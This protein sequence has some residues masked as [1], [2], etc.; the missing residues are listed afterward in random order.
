MK[1]YLSTLLLFIF[2]LSSCQNKRTKTPN[3]Q[4]GTQKMVDTLRY[5]VK[6]TD[7]LKDYYASELRANYYKEEMEKADP[8]KRATLMYSWLKELINSGDNKTAIASIQDFISNLKLDINE[9]D[10][11]SRYFFELLALAYLR[12]GEL[13]NCVANHTAES[14][15]FPLAEN[16]I[17]TL[18]SGST[19]AIKIYKQI[20]TR[21]PEDLNSRWLLNVAFMTLGEYPDKV[22]S[23]WLIKGLKPEKK[24]SPVAPFKNVAVGM[25]IDVN[26][27]S[28][29]VCLDDFNNDGNLDIVISSWGPDHQLRVFISDGKGAYTEN[30]EQSGIKGITGG[31][32]LVHADYDN[33]GLLDVFVLRGAWKGMDGQIPNSLL[34]NKGNGQFEDVTFDSGLLSFHPTQVATW[35]DFNNDGWLDLFIANETEASAQSSHPCEFYLNKKNGTFENVASKVGLNVKG[36][37]KGASAG[38]I[39]NDGWIDLFLSNL[40]GSNY[41]FLNEGASS[42]EQ[43]KFKDITKLANVAAPW[44]SFPTW[45]WDYDNDGWLDIFVSTYDSRHM[46][47][48][49]EDEALQMLNMEG[50]VRYPKLYKNKGNNLFSDVTEGVGLNRVMYPMGSNFGDLDNDGYQDFYL[51]TGAP[52]LRSVVPN[53]MFYNNGGTSFQDISYEVGMGHIQKGH[54]IGFADLDNDGDQDIYAVMGGAYPGDVFFN[55]LFE[56]PNNQ[57][58]WLT[59]ALEGTTTN[60]SAIG[61]RIRVNVSMA[62]G[63]DKDFYVVV[64]TGGSFGSSSLQQEMGLGDATKINEIEIKWANKNQT[65]ERFT[66]VALNKRYSIKEGTQKAVEMKQPSFEFAKGGGHEHY[67]H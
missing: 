61:T 9:M 34:K 16:S 29:G 8:R 52:D 18:K 37:F 35:A 49:G 40:D 4:S 15:I 62:N 55:A 36:F 31:L 56:N 23:Q 59:L 65:V 20:L 7:P 12:D 17:H 21:F 47:K 46:N 66:E 39:N 41:L 60:R 54:G 28:G 53:L 51:G 1:S 44:H 6:H 22:P 14:C 45:F 10:K 27:L 63:K 2:L 11:N 42:P 19:E 25:G 5:F 58:T 57:N 64:G 24:Q 48:V 13:E 3:I 33:D 67:H 38:D 32:N 43:L 26:E 30:I 50:D